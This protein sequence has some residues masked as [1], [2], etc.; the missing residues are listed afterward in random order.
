MDDS[1]KVGDFVW[2]NGKKVVV[3]KIN[4]SKIWLRDNG[5]RMDPVVL[6]KALESGSLLRTK[7]ELEL[8]KPEYKQQVISFDAANEPTH[9][10]SVKSSRDSETVKPATIHSESEP[11]ANIE[12]EMIEVPEGGWST[13][14]RDPHS[15]PRVRVGER[16]KTKDYGICTVSELRSGRVYMKNSKGKVV[17]FMYPNAFVNKKVIKV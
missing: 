2:F 16:Y 12:P 11:V 6:A 9:P 5:R 3:D 13:D 17:I 10:Y 8:V 14:P 7:P 4:D 15:N 1:I